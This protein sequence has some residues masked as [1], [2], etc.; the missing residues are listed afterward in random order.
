MVRVL[1]WRSKF[2][3]ILVVALTIVGCSDS[4][5]GATIYVSA[6]S[7]LQESLQEVV[8][9]FNEKHPDVEVMLNFAGS[10]V[11]RR[12]IEEGFGVDIFLSAH[13]IPFDELDQ[14]G[15]IAEGQRFVQNSV[16]LVASTE[17]IE[18]INDLANEGVS[19]ILA[20]D[21]VPIGIY[22]REII[23]MVDDNNAGFAEAVLANVVSQGENVR[24]VLM[25]VVLQEGDVAFVYRT[26]ITPDVQDEVIVIELPDAYQV[27]T[28]VYLALINRENISESA[29]LFYEFILSDVSREV[30]ISHGFR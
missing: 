9:L 10:N 5:N 18:S 29:S 25:Q 16:V 1:K 23:E 17:Q 12:Q 26:D 4:N 8:V 24:Q 3:I 14:I 21:S 11:L 19:I 13:F 30:F 20:N 28:D 7:S 22:S 27:T 15:L 2:L 6:A